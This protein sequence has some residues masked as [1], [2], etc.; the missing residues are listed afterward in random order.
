MSIVKNNV[1]IAVEE[2][3]L[4]PNESLKTRIFSDCYSSY[5]VEDFQNLGFILKRVNHFVWC[6][7]VMVYSITTQLNLCGVKLK[8]ILVILVVFLLII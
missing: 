7:L 3:N 5:Q 6:G 1:T 4:P 8:P 2:E